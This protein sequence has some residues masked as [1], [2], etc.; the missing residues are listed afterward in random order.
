MLA[1]LNSNSQDSIMSPRRNQ[2]T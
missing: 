2:L 1:C